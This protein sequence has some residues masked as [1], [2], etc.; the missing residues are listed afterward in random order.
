MADRRSLLAVSS[1]RTVMMQRRLVV[2]RGIVQGIGFR[3]FVYNLATGLGL[4]GSVRNQTGSVQ[5][6]EGEDPQLDGF[7]AELTAQPPPLARIKQVTWEPVAPGGT[8]VSD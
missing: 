2:V 6:A 3:P 1:S 8:A 4:T 7:V 5:I